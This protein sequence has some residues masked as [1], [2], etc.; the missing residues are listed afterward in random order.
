MDVT[1]WVTTRRVV[2]VFDDIIYTKSC[3]QKGDKIS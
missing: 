3:N 1:L 2:M